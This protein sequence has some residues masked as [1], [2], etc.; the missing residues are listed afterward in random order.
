[1]VTRTKS[2]H[3]ASICSRASG[4]AFSTSNVD[5]GYQNWF[6]NHVNNS[7]R[8]YIRGF[9]EVPHNIRSVQIQ[10]GWCFE[11]LDLS[12]VLLPVANLLD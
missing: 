7:K 11:Q 6:M 1:M 12:K 9:K 5:S 2:P 8:G 4:F 10:V 3:H